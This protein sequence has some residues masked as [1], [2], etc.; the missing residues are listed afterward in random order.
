[1]ITK[2]R[3]RIITKIILISTLVLVL[4][5]SGCVDSSIYGTY[6]F[7]GA[8]IRLQEDNTYLY[9]PAN[10]FMQKGTFTQNGDEIQLT[11]A[12]GTAVVMKIVQNG[13]VVTDG[14]EKWVKQ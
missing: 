14:N 11:S 12:F 1:M 9:T 4:L 3:P 6:T 7:N 5:L 10:G 8:I 2:Y 13:L